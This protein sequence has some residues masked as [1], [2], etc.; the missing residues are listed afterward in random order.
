MTLC[1]DDYYHNK[2]V[3]PGTFHAGGWR[4][5]KILH[6]VFKFKRRPLSLKF[7]HS[8]LDIHSWLEIIF[9]GVPQV[10][11]QRRHSSVKGEQLLSL[12]PLSSLQRIRISPAAGLDLIFLFEKQ[13]TII[14][15]KVLWE[16]MIFGKYG[17]GEKKNTLHSGFYQCIN[18][19]WKGHF[20]AKGFG[21]SKHISVASQ[22]KHISVRTRGSSFV[23]LSLLWLCL[24]HGKCEQN[25]ESAEFELLGHPW[26]NLLE[27]KLQKS[28][29]VNSFSLIIPVVDERLLF[30]TFFL[31]ERQQARKRDCVNKM[32]TSHD[33]S[34]QLRGT[35]SM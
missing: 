29:I 6:Y 27:M 20:C 28:G 33:S 22:S 13:D 3:K 2:P 23:K 26:T 19:E 15:P 1:G 9:Q 7:R 10:P 5:S 12:S 30:D 4:V 16:I 31:H 18:E 8:L 21:D 17:R 32:W 34:A 11:E 35:G 14:S 25:K 24:S